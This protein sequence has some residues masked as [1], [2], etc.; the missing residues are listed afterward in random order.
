[1]T[2]SAAADDRSLVE[3]VFPPSAPRY[4]EI[5]RERIDCLQ[6]GT[7]RTHPMGKLI[8]DPALSPSVSKIK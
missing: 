7:L 8:Y 4:I 3:R 6:E 5:A 1:M 2:A